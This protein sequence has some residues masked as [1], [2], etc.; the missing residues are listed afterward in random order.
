MYS[1][2][3][4][5]NYL[6]F[7]LKFWQIVL[8]FL[9]ISLSSIV[10]YTQTASPTPNDKIVI[11]EIQDGQVFS[12]GK[13]VVIKK[14]VKE[15]L[16]FGGDIIVEGKV[17]GDVATIGGSI[18]QKENAFI[19]G[20]VIVIGGKYQHD[21][22]EPLRNEGKETIMYAVYEEELRNMT[23]DPT[24]LF[25]PQFTWSFIVWRLLSTLFWF[26]V[27]LAIV[28]IAPGAISRATARFQLSTAKVVGLGLACFIFITIGVVLGFS[29]LPTNISGIIGV[30]ATFIMFLAYVF[31][32]VA[33]QVSAGKWLQKHLLPEKIHSESLSIFIGSLILTILLSLPYIWTLTVFLLF[34]TSLGLVLT[35]RSSTNWQK[36]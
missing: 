6:D 5:I 7:G 31:G 12:F 24:Q 19:G 8:A 9:F 33:L 26:I 21:R 10:I 28:T 4:R 22:T 16:V 13:T 29:F 34:S 3:I 14:E 36:V 35:A 18:I 17:E 15:V 23:Q 25:S 20:D 2:A 30:M 27:A 11:D 1:D 32:R